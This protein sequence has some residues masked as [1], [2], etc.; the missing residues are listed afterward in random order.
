MQPFETR[1]AAQGAVTTDGPSPLSFPD[2]SGRAGAGNYT[3]NGGAVD[4]TITK[5]IVNTTT[6]QNNP[7]HPIDINSTHQNSLSVFN[8]PD[9]VRLHMDL[10]GQSFNLG[11]LTFNPNHYI[12]AFIFAPPGG[13]PSSVD[14]IEVLPGDFGGN[15]SVDA[16]DYPI[17]KKAPGLAPFLTSY[18]VWKSNFGDALGSGSGGGSSD[19]VPEPTSLLLLLT[20]A[21]C[22]LISRRYRIQKENPGWLAQGW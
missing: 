17:W 5:R 12:D 1:F 13:F 8:Y 20:S 11:R 15:G 14:L 18:D 21:C 16:A 19:G 2:I 22:L 10:S 6:V 9:F 4:W 7:L 3:F